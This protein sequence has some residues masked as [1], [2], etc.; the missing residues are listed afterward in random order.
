MTDSVFQ[1]SV[2]QQMP[3]TLSFVDA[4]GNVGTAPAGVPAWAVDHPE[5]LALTVAEDGMS[6]EAIPTTL[7]GVAV[8][9]VTLD[10]LTGTLAITIVGGAVASITVV[11]GT[12]VAKA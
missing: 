1:L 10:A 12:P 3:V 8:V 7:E 11:P 2:E 5:L 4:H 6:A 9:T